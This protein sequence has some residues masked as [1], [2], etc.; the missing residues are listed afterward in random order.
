VFICSF[1]PKTTQKVFHVNTTD[2]PVTD[3]LKNPIKL[4]TFVNSKPKS[5]LSI[6]RK[7]H[8]DIT[9]ATTEIK[10]IESM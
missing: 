7:Y 10:Q 1:F 9:P 2:N 4:I 3:L 6:G 5:F 8:P